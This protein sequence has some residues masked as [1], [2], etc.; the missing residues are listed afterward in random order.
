MVSSL[1]PNLQQFVDS[2]NGITNSLQRTQLEISSGLRINQLSDSP[3]TISTLLTARA[4]LSSVQQ[5]NSN[6]GR[7]QSEA[8]GGE[9]ALE[10]AVQ[11][12]DHVQT[13]GAQGATDTVDA[14]TRANLAT[15]LGSILQQ[16]GGL[17][18]TQ[19]EGRYI[20]SG[21]SDQQTPYIIDLTQANP[22]SAYMGSASTRLARRA[23]RMTDRGQPRVRASSVRY[24]PCP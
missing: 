3:D 11:L 4:S 14:A 9:Q 24:S 13:L 19:V 18:A 17:A 22:V 15:Q 23:R 2:F 21:D 12:F 10:T 8:N 6:L 16:M 7:F 1:N 20:F 5:I